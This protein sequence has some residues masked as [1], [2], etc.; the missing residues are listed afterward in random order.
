MHEQSGQGR[1]FKVVTVLLLCALFF[2]FAVGVTLLGSNVYAEAVNN[3]DE[4]FEHRT[5]LSYIVN[6]IWRA[7][8]VDGISVGTFGDG[9]ALFMHEMGYVTILYT[10]E[11]KLCELYISNDI[12]IDPDGGNEIVDLSSMDLEVENG[13]LLKIKVTSLGGTVY[14]TSVAPKNGVSEEGAE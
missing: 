11:G 10:Y 2:I 14:E 1:V 6:Q 9:D 7:D 8:I 12:E 4:N 5:T 3:S 13:E